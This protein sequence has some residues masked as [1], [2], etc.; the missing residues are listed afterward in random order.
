MIKPH[1][2]SEG[3]DTEVV[4]RGVKVGP[5]TRRSKGKVKHLPHYR[6]GKRKQDGGLIWSA[7]Q[8]RGTI[9]RSWGD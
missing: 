6:A 3:N 4:I 2:V 7:R 5:A 8:G 1:H 9:P